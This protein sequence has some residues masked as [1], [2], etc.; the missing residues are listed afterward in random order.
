ME[1]MRAEERAPAGSDDGRPADGRWPTAAT[2]IVGVIGDPVGHSLSP[3]L[4]NTAFAVLGLDWVSVGFQVPAGAVAEALA[5][6]RALQ[7]AGLS[8]TM[9]HKADAAELVDE[10]TAVAE[11]LHAV[12]CVQRSGDRLVGDNTDGAGFLAGLRRGA[13]LDPGNCRAMVIGAGGAARAV[14][15]ALA[16]AGA[17]EVVVVARTRV[18]AEAAAALAGDRGRVG[19]SGDA[20]GMDLVVDATPAGMGGFAAG[21]P[22]VDA[23]L[24]GPGQ[25]AVDLVYD[26]PITA[27]LA[28][29]AA[30]G[31]TVVGGLGMLVHQAEAQLAAWTG[32]VPPVE[33]MWDAAVQAAGGARALQAG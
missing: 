32:A 31:A 19:S 5:G 15:L 25:V 26:P 3:L 27:W 10:R 4:H 28:T 11:Q 7:I 6:M 22:F 29:A 14:I 12:N 33:A 23:A 8:V 1:W 13:A 21:A 20:P 16:E 2:T 18:R 24:L 30:H 17:T 9:P